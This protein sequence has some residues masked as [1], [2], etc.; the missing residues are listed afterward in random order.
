MLRE[1]DAGIQTGGARTGGQRSDP[2]PAPRSGLPSPASQGKADSQSQSSSDDFDLDWLDGLADSP[3]PPSEVGSFRRLNRRD[4]ESV[5]DDLLKE[6]NGGRR[7]A[8]EDRQPWLREKQQQS[9]LYLSARD[10]DK[11]RRWDNRKSPS[12]PK[13]DE[14]DSFAAY[15]DALVNFEKTR[16]QAT[17]PA[18]LESVAPASVSDSVPGPFL[19]S[20]LDSA[21]SS[22]GK[23]SNSDRSSYGRDRNGN[24]DRDRESDQERES[25]GERE[26][27]RKWGKPDKVGVYSSANLD[28]EADDS[29]DSFLLSEEDSDSGA[30]P[31][32]SPSSSRVD[33][34]SDS[35]PAEGQGRSPM[36]SGGV[37]GWENL[38]LK[39]LKEQCRE[40]GLKVSGT[41][42]DLVSRLV[43]SQS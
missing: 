23:I 18:P 19:D 35:N 5:L 26:R 28:F 12:A 8:E 3:A 30:S 22:A 41:K 25:D 15:L 6:L 36:P 9:S 39:A 40:L 27:D 7:D 16:G 10:K 33:S 21:S 32:P 31:L 29:A 42:A 11:E 4:S 37:S 2:R 14:F 34:D 17:A 24:G 43:G 20:V 1:V 13:E 38:S